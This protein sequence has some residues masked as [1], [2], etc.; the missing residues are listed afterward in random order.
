[1]WSTTAWTPPRI[2]RTGTTLRPGRRPLGSWPRVQRAWRRWRN[3][4]T[5]RGRPRRATPRYRRPLWQ[6]RP[7]LCRALRRVRNR[8]RA[9]GERAICRCGRYGVHAVADVNDSQSRDRAHV[10]HPA[11]S[12]RC[13][14]ARQLR[15]R[16]FLMSTRVEDISDN[17]FD[18]SV[19][20]AVQLLM[21]LFLAEMNSSQ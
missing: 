5:R 18:V 15:S 16:R 3:R 14:R 19:L 17:E 6:L 4:R 9:L 10:R 12:S 8:P 2:E 13:F 11:N 1:M 21:P 7:V 20:G